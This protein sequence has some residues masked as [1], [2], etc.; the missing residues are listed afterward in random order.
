MGSN[1][2]VSEFFVAG[3]TLKLDVLSYVKR[4]ADEELFQWA[5]AGK[6]C[7]V[8]TSR[9]V[10]KSSLMVRTAERLKEGGVSTAS[11]DLTKSETHI[12]NEQWY[13]WLIT[14]LE[15]SFELSVDPLT[16]WA[17]RD[18]LGAVQRFS[19][20]LH[21]VVLDQIEGKVVIFVDEIDSTLKLD[22]SD[23]FFA[24]IRACYNARATD[25]VYDRLTFVL[26]GVATPADLM[27]DRSRTPFNIGQGIELRD[28]GREDAQVLREG[29]RDTC[30]EEADAVFKRIFEWTNGHP[31][32][33]QLLCQAVIN[34]QD[35][36]CAA[37][38]VDELVEKSFL[39]EEAHDEANLKFVQDRILS[40][41]EAQ[42][43]ELLGLY[44]RVY[45]GK[46]VEDNAQS[47]TQNELKLAGLVE[48][49]AGCLHVRNNIYRQAFGE[50]WIKTNTPIDWRR[51]LFAV[52]VVMVILFT[53]AIFS[54]WLPRQ[55]AQDNIDCFRGADYTPDEKVACLTLLL[56]DA[57][58]SFGDDAQQF[59]IELDKAQQHE[60]FQGLKSQKAG[61]QHLF[62]LVTNCYANLE[63]ND[64]DNAFL[65]TML[66]S[67]EQLDN[68]DLRE[69]LAYWRRWGRAYQSDYEQ[70]EGLKYELEYWLAGRMAYQLE[71]YGEAV[72]LYKA[73]I[74]LN[75]EN[76]SVFFDRGLAYLKLRKLLDALE[77]FKTVLNLDPTREQRVGEELSGAPDL[78]EA[79]IANPSEYPTMVALVPAPTSTPKATSTPTPAPT[80]IMADVS[81]TPAETPVPIST[82]TL[83]P[84]VI[85]LASSE[86]ARYA[87]VE[88]ARDGKT[89]QVH[90]ADG[91]LLPEHTA[92]PAWSPDGN[93]LAY[94]GEPGIRQA[95]G[96]WDDGEGIWIA[97]INEHGQ[98]A[99][100]NR[101]FPSEDEHSDEV[102][103]RDH[104][105]NIA[106]SPDEE[107]IAFEVE[108]PNNYYEIWVIDSKGGRK[109]AV[110][111]GRQ[112]AWLDKDSLIIN[113]EDC[114]PS[115]GLWQVNLSGK[116]EDELT[117]H[118]GDGYPAVLSKEKPEDGRY[119]AFKRSRGY[120]DIY[121][122]DLA[123]E[124][125]DPIQLT[126]LGT[127]TTPAFG[128]SGQKIYFGYEFAGDWY[129][130]SNRLNL[131]DPD[132]S[133][134]DPNY[135][136]VQ[137]RVGKSEEL[138]LARPAIAPA[139]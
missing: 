30:S 64:E 17:E 117:N 69:R 108:L 13:L 118:D 5:S 14:R 109:K 102:S 46:R 100:H 91:D 94:I 49:E 2:T 43:R 73:V 128:P 115:C 52:S 119:L 40:R 72:G 22:F 63:N 54:Y 53:V 124:S 122:L 27:K 9:Q 16:W 36:S 89:H 24:A 125:S 139:Q 10:G 107:Y 75:D 101:L 29:L 50:D 4:P 65:A 131:E 38:R 7:Y 67:L 21:D 19:D 123:K 110:I 28:F 120:D 31:Y 112:P 92:A 93:R 59:F 20:F 127:A 137:P 99:N 97:G 132:Q 129:I 136:T 32:L 78:Y 116:Y 1:S 79:V 71:N 68:Q 121:I 62:V 35:G 111:P 90:I 55:K 15:R 95:G 39:S 98:A 106:W 8:L 135:Q 81:A 126:E 42:R 56:E 57:P 83:T 77:D 130:M 6:F 113:R 138:G 51:R 87:F 134:E 96:V 105:K 47:L 37:Q 88:T 41:P 76:P 84:T 85:V 26:L 60:V 103:V 133:R 58:R 34:D 104:I 86:P 74:R 114:A 12:S 70:A 44:K 3:G 48:T 25:P 33:T 18:S 82:L 61:P 80:D 66:D 11:I 45:S 23:D